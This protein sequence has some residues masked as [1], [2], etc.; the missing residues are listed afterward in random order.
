MV[1]ETV[2]SRVL[3]LLSVFSRSWNLATC[4]LVTL[5]LFAFEMEAWSDIKDPHLELVHYA[6]VV[7]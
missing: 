2:D 6:P 5:A 7:N 4:F 1:A 3:Q